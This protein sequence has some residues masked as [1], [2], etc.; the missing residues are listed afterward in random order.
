MI[1][2]P[3][4]I[5]TLNRNLIN[6]YGKDQSTNLPNWRI[7]WSEDQFEFRQGEYEDRTSEG[8]LIRRVNE[9][10]FVPKY[11][12]WTPKKWCLEGLIPIPSINAEELPSSKLSYELFYAFPYK[13]GKPLIPVWP[14]VRLVIEEVLRKVNAR[15][16]GPLYR[17]PENDPVVA[18]GMKEQRLKELEEDL[19]GN[20]TD[21]GD[22]LAYKQGIIVPGGR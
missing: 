12:Q 9:V 13:D 11:R 14:A 22:A 2:L 4:E 16:Q 15:G 19:F 17:D 6:F 18:D 7:V 3:V 10:R 21:V 5:E 8:L 1:D 20:E